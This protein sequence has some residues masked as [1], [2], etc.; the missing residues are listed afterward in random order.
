MSYPCRQENGV[1]IECE[2]AISLYVLK[3]T[4]KIDGVFISVH[5][6]IFF[7]ACAPQI[8]D[9]VGKSQ[10]SLTDAWL[11]NDSLN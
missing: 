2:V 6:S 10:R 1:K 4:N 11:D 8:G 7:H 5:M 9:F 3:D